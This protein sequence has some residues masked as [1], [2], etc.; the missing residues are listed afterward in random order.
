MIK[1]MLDTNICIYLIK[2]K[3][4]KVLEHLK[5]HNIGEIGI[6]SITLAELQY[7]VA[8]SLYK[9][10]NEIALEEF[11]MPLEI[12]PF[13]EKAAEFYGTMRTQLE[14]AGEPIGSL[15]TLIGAHALSIG[16]TLVTNNLKE[17][18]RIKKLKV[19]DWTV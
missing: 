6:S 12:L 5:S 10:Q 17:F 7:G 4:L 15:D 13:H 9:Q 14:K 2:Q 16:I 8:K 19:V 3:P 11:A 1:F 18:K